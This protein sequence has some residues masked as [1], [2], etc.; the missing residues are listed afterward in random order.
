MKLSMVKPAAAMVAA[1]SVLLGTAGTASA[2]VLTPT[3]TNCAAQTL[4]QPF[5]PWLDPFS[6]T[7]VPGGTFEGSL[8]GWTLADGARV[9]SGNEPWKVGGSPDGASLRL[10][11]GSSALSAPICVGLGDPTLRFFAR[12][13]SGL[14]STLAVSVRVETTLGVAE[15]PIGAVAA[16]SSWTPTLPYAML[17]NLLPV[18]P[19]DDAAVQFRFTP[20]LGGDWQV[21][22]IYVDPF[23]RA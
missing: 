21:D 5:A 18:L 22:D 19:G 20:L 14:L 10:P 3:A 7:P 17:V 11:R 12:R 23:R 13:N 2:G 9:V 8:G 4:S 1:A 16:G 6:Y 15:V